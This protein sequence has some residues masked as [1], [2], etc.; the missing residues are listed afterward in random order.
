MHTRWKVHELLNLSLFFVER[1]MEDS[2]GII[3]DSR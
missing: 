3:R 2:E 1:L